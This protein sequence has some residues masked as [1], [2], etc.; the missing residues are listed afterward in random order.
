[1]NHSEQINEL[2]TALAK[3]QGSMRHA[4]KDS[5]NPHFKSK[6][7]DLASVW[8]ACREPLATNGLAVI[9]TVEFTKDTGEILVTTLG[10]SSGQWIKSH[11]PLPIQ[12]PGP[13]ELGSCL[14]Y[15]RRYSLAAMVG[16]FQDDD[17]GESAQKTYREPIKTVEQ[18]KFE[19]PVNEDQIKILNALSVEF[20]NTVPFILTKYG[21][22]TLDFLKH[23]DF[24]HVL[25]VFD[26]ARKR[27]NE[28]NGQN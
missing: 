21:I 20:P 9:Q 23:K 13:Q 10:H 26:T 22:P 15:C 4:V 24:E 25:K 28:A 17:D 16:V 14:S 3:A 5:T 19:P 12:K 8:E 11:M 2:M 6:Y 18:P 1:M 27:R 7:A